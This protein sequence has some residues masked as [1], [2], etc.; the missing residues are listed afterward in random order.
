[1]GESQP[2]PPPLRF[3]RSNLIP[4]EV[5]LSLQVKIKNRSLPKRREVRNERA[6]KNKARRKKKTKQ[7]SGQALRAMAKDGTRFA[8]TPLRFA[9]AT[10]FAWSCFA[11]PTAPSLYA[12]WGRSFLLRSH[13]TPL[14]MSLK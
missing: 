2:K 3:W 6:Q 8:R 4:Y 5:V 14:A 1:M 12:S 10:S 11:G 13:P 9:Q 7:A